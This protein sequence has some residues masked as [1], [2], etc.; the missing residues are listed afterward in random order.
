M[1]NGKFK[2]PLAPSQNKSRQWLAN[3]FMRKSSFETTPGFDINIELKT[4]N[5]KEQLKFANLS[6]PQ[7]SRIVKKSRVS[8]KADRILDA[9]DV[10]NDYYLNLLSWSDDDILAVALSNKVY[11]WNS[12]T[13]TV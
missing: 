5:I 6:S 4:N 3:R 11:L 7:G 1:S 13:G 9:P 10:I 2:T 12:V 8:S